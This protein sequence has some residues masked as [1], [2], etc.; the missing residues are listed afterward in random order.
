MRVPSLYRLLAVVTVSLIAS[1]CA[2][3]RAGG[4]RDTPDCY[5]DT[6]TSCLSA[7]Q[8]LAENSVDGCD[9]TGRRVCLVPLGTVDA[10]LVERLVAH[11]ADEY[12]LQVRVLTP[13]P[14][15]AGLATSATNQI[16]GEDLIDQMAAA[17]PSEAADSDVT[18]IGLTPLDIYSRESHY[19][20]LFG[21][22]GTPGDP[23]AVISTFRMDPE[24]LGFK[25]N[26]GLL[27]DRMEKMLS[28]YIGLL[29]FGLPLTD[30]PTSPLTGQVLGLADLDRIRGGLPVSGYVR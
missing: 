17:F 18:L 13:Q 4:V 10:G 14:V 27:F 9:G 1:G 16:D 11:Y 29:Y 19:N 23:K 7:Q 5:L 21:T 2:H 15:P 3:V 8:D 25:P 22:K 30:D 26:D 24:S 28:R 6:Y 20:F 12:G